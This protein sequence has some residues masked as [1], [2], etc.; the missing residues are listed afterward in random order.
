V[1]GHLAGSEDQLFAGCVEDDP[2]PFATIGFLAKVA[3][4][5]SDCR[6][7]FVIKL[8]I[9]FQPPPKAEAEA[10]A[11]QPGKCS[12]LQVIPTYCMFYVYA[13]GIN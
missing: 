12:K 5:R 11:R 4:F 9:D 6:G 1:A 8:A 10:S 2:I 7:L 13:H 3:A